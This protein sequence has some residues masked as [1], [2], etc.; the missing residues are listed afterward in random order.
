MAS[1]GE[2]SDKKGGVSYQGSMSVAQLRQTLQSLIAGLDAGQIVLEHGEEQ[3][4]LVPADELDLTI[5]VKQKGERE[6]LQMEISWQRSAEEEAE[7]PLRITT[8]PATSP[9]AS[10]EA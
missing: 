1:N 3:A 8:T 9:S 10:S 2:K 6:G 4:T 7:E 5:K